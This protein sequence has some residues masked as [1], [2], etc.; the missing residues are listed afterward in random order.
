MCE[1]AKK[2]AF[3][4]TLDQEEEYVPPP[5]DTLPPGTKFNGYVLATFL[6]VSGAPNVNGRQYDLM[7]RNENWWVHPD[8]VAFRPN[9]WRLVDAN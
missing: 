4:T 7:L 8:D 6:P 3:F 9:W 1:C 2:G 5:R